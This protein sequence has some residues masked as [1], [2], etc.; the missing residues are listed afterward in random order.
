MVDPGLPRERGINP[1]DGYANV[2]FGKMFAKN[3]K[4]MKE[5]GMRGGVRS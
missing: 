5:I 2:L 3:S 1:R 4:K